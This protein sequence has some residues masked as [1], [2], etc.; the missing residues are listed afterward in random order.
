[1]A[2]GYVA[3]E[4]DSPDLSAFLELAAWHLEP[5]YRYE[6]PGWLHAVGRT[7]WRLLGASAKPR[8]PLQDIVQH[9]D[10][11]NDFY[12]AWLDETMTYSSAVFADERMTLA[13]AQAEKYRRLAAATG[14][15][16]ERP[17]ARDRI[18]LGWVR[19]GAGRRDRLPRHHDHRLQAAA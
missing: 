14:I 11:G 2:D 5:A 4:Y 13:E 1:M 19:R 16:P 17:R 15:G 7:A 8:G 9:Y 10:L 6:V 18:G 12:E 3:G